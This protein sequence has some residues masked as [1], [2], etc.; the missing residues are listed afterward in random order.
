MMTTF[1]PCAPPLGFIASRGKGGG[2]FRIGSGKS[3]RSHRCG[4]VPGLEAQCRSLMNLQGPPMP[5]SITA[6]RGPIDHCKEGRS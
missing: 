6:K 5:I 2:N 4:P 1:R 3:T